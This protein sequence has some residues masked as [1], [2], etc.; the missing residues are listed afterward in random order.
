MVRR[1]LRTT[2]FTFYDS[3]FLIFF[4]YFRK[5]KKTFLIVP[6]DAGVRSERDL[7]AEA[8]DVGADGG[9]RQQ[10]GRKTVVCSQ[11]IRCC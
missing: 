5:F 2:V 9:R 8:Q 4:L 11:K 6:T 7:D 1:V 10:S 3:V